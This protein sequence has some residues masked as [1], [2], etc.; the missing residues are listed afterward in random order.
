M[1]RN[2]WQ[3]YQKEV[4]DDNYYYLRS[5]IRQNFFPGSER[6]FVRILREELGRNLYDDPA[7]TSCTG[8]GYHSDV[9]LH[10]TI[11][12][13]VARQFALM[14]EAGYENAAVSCITSFGIYTE[15]LETWREFP[16]VEERIRE[17]L[18]KATGREFYKPRNLAHTSDIIFHHRDAIRQRAK[19]LLV[20]HRTGEPLRGVEHIGCHYA[21]IFP[22][23]GIGGVE[24]PY[25]LAGM[26]EAW[27]GQVVD[28]PE[29]RHCCGFG[30]RNYLVQA[31]RGYSIA[32]SQKK[33][34]SMA[35]Y[36][37][38]FIL[39]NCPGCGMFLD[40]WQY[41][42]AEI[43]GTTYGQDGK[44]IPVLTY[45]ELA[46]LVLGYDPWDLGLQMHQVDVEPLLDKLGVEYDPAAKYLMPNGRYIGRPEPAAVNMGV[47]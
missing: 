6:A 8:I 5:C 38:D 18:Y 21:K 11:M 23:E 25:V 41:T 32:N 35:L 14:K 24:F 39:T 27:G 29:R 7:H 9:V 2:T 36:K 17:H 45:E 42:I 4:A 13:V 37:P 16:E 26:I 1:K 44:G 19:H 28:Y 34:E 46:G 12:T 3:E 30:F 20:D 10:D 33:L 40:K 43:E 15:V 22:K 47:E 31:N